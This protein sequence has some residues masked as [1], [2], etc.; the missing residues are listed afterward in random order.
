MIRF[1]FGEFSRDADS[2]DVRTDSDVFVGSYH[3][4]RS[5][6]L[7]ISTLGIGNRLFWINDTPLQ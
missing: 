7:W 4:E 6:A 1:R 5:I 3:D 2:D